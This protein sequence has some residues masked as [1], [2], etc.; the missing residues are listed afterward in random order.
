MRKYHLNI[1]PHSVFFFF[2]SFNNRIDILYFILQPKYSKVKRKT[3]LIN[4]KIW[5]LVHDVFVAAVSA[6]S[7]CLAS[8]I[9]QRKLLV[10]IEPFMYC[11]FKTNEQTNKKQKK[12]CAF[13]CVLITVWLICEHATKRMIPNQLKNINFGSKIKITITFRVETVNRR[14]F[15]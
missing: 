7:W 6:Y 14:H 11:L 8:F 13:I 2:N 3:K 5:I 1:F 12:M 10:V 9:Q 4:F 15:Y